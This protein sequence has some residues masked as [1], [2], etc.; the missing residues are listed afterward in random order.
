[1]CVAAQSVDYAEI[2]ATTAAFQSIRMVL[3]LATFYSMQFWKLDIKTFFLYGDLQEKIYM[4]QPPGYEVGNKACALTKSLYGL[5]QSMRCA[6][7]ALSDQLALQQ[8]F[9][10]KS[11]QNFLSE[12]SRWCRDS[13]CLGG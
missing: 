9:P 2:F 10:L 3:W 4:K 13:V 7:K 12:R 6:L 1:M 8:I 11:D 5:K